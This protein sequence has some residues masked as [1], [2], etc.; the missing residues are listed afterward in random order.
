MDACSKH[1]R[2]NLIIRT[3]L[4]IL[5]LSAG[6]GAKADV[7]SVMQGWA[8]CTT[9][10]EKNAS[11]RK[12]IGIPYSGYRW[13]ARAIR[14]AFVKSRGRSPVA[15]DAV[16][17]WNTNAS[18]PVVSSPQRGDLAFRRYSH[19]EVVTHV[20]GNTVC[21]VSGNTGIRVVQRCASK[22]KFK[23]FRRP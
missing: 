2:P 19:V 5:F 7:V 8:N 12:A 16:A 14:T 3:L 11:F 20:K 1:E 15:S 9:C 22:S 23:N 17:N 10:T 6:A 21:T 18:G 13:C 4:V